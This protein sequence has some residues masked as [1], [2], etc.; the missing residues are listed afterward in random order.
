MKKIYLVNESLDEFAGRRG[1][2]RKNAPRRAPKAIADEFGDEPEDNWYAADD[3]FDADDG[4][5]PEQIEDVE[6]EDEVTD[7]AIQKQIQ[8][9]L[10]NE[11]ASPEFNRVSVKFRSPTGVD[12]GIPMAKMGDAFLLKLKNGGMK[13]VKVQDMM[14]ES[15]KY[16]KYKKFVAES[17]NQYKKISESLFRDYENIEDWEQNTNPMEKK[18]QL[19]TYLQYYNLP[20]NQQVSDVDPFK[21]IEFVNDLQNKRL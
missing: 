7:I 19:N 6:L 14:A 10:E 21:F 15:I 3:E 4:P 5:G 8:K 16:K 12:Q 13:K 9:R 2:P 18:T 11:L 20:M 17:F 1:R